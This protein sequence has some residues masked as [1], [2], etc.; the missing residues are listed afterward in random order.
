MG[1]H[2]GFI[3]ENLDEIYTVDRSSVSLISLVSLR[4]PPIGPHENERAV[5]TRVMLKVDQVVSK[6]TG[7]SVALVVRIRQHTSY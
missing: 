5:N 4:E 2:Q 3:K 6:T 7:P 1:A